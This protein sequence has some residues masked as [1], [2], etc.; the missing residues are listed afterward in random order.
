VTDLRT[1]N[2]FGVRVTDFEMLP[3][4]LAEPER[5]GVPML[6]RAVVPMFCL[7]GGPKN[8]SGGPLGLVC[9]TPHGKVIAPKAKVSSAFRISRPHTFMVASCRVAVGAL[10]DALQVSVPAWKKETPRSHPPDRG[11]LL[12]TRAQRQSH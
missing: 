2:P 5:A 10:P 7:H 12:H 3:E 9:A 8:L 6:G 1:L 11:I 4:R